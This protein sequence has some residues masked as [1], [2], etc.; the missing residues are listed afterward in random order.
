MEATVEFRGG[1]N[2]GLFKFLGMESLSSLH[3]PLISQE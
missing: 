3:L 2:S 1:T